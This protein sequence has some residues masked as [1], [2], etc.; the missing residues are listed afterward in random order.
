[1]RSLASMCSNASSEDAFDIAEFPS[2]GDIN[3][4]F[5][6]ADQQRKGASNFTTFPFPPSLAQ[7]PQLHA[8]ADEAATSD[9]RIFQQLA[10]LGQRGSVQGLGLFSSAG[11]DNFARAVSQQS[12]RSRSST[13][14][15]SSTLSSKSFDASTLASSAAN[16]SY[17]MRDKEADMEEA[18]PAEL[19]TTIPWFAQ[20][21]PTTTSRSLPPPIDPVL[22]NASSAHPALAS[23]FTSAASPTTRYAA[24]SSSLPHGKSPVTSRAPVRLESLPVESPAEKLDETGTAQWAPPTSWALM[25]AEEFLESPFEEKEVLMDELP[26][27]PMSAPIVRSNIPSSPS[28][29]SFPKTLKRFSSLGL[30]R[31]KKSEAV[32]RDSTAVKTNGA[33]AKDEA[34]PGLVKRK[35]EAALASLLRSRSGGGEKDKENV[36]AAPPNFRPVLQPV[37]LQTSKSPKRSA[38]SPRLAKLFSATPADP[39]APAVPAKDEGSSRLKKRLSSYFNQPRGGPPAPPLPVATSSTATKTRPPAVD[40][41]KANAGLGLARLVT[42]ESAQAS[43][44]PTL[45]ASTPS[46]VPPSSIFSE[47]LPPNTSS[48]LYSSFAASSASSLPAATHYALDNPLPQP[49][50]TTCFSAPPT[51]TQFPPLVPPS[52]AERPVSLMGFIDAPVRS[53]SVFP[54]T[55]LAQKRL[56]ARKTA[57]THSTG[58]ISPSGGD[59]RPTSLR[60]VDVLNAQPLSRQQFTA[61]VATEEVIAFPVHLPASH[62][63]AISP[64]TGS[65]VSDDEYGSESVSSDEDDDQPLGANPAALTA[66]KSLRLSAAKKS[67]RERKAREAKELEAKQ[68]ARQATALLKAAAKPEDPFELEKTAAMVGTSA[69]QDTRRLAPAQPAHVRPPISPAHSTPMVATVQSAGHASLLP[70]TDASIMRKATSFGM[71][72]SPS[73][74]LDPMVADSSLTIDSPELVQRPLPKRADSRLATEN[75]RSKSPTSTNESAMPA[76][77]TLAVTDPSMRSPTVASPSPVPPFRPPSV[78]STSA[79]SSSM[80]AFDRRPSAHRKVS[81]STASSAAGTPPLGRRPSL[82]PDSRAPAAAKRKVSESSTT[83]ASPALSRTSTLASRSRSATVSSAPPVEH[84]IYVDASFSKYLKVAVTDKTLAGEVV[85]LGKAKGALSKTTASEASEGGWALWEAWRST[86]LGEHVGSSVDS[87]SLTDEYRVRRRTTD[88]R[89]RARQRRPQVLGSGVERALLS[90]N[91][92]VAHLVRPCE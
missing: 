71:T 10:Q 82:H 37:Q 76:I 69:S 57:D 29:A 74:P 43:P 19:T 68:Q 7:D 42:I 92:N 58:A 64:C 1:M 91:N 53:T 46:S 66:Q 25:T 22:A 26:E 2:I 3:S 54:T 6:L 32:L 16:T 89:V 51:Q 87:S 73:S 86:G 70:Q 52:P 80:S 55:K 15:D 60:L 31:K 45:G 14:S 21:P 9:E 56:E 35:S 83:S 81:D 62:A 50:S 17:G 8:G 4:S 63:A 61:P 39:A 34:R 49:L 30:L 12:S 77:E 23:P 67:R 44:V 48:P 27:P 79:A 78:P 36:S 40:V 88:P 90:T 65:E 41:A 33:L 85:S 84:R 28:S 18:F 11:T 75:K 47:A 20:S 59:S 5:E 13:I 24:R 38:S 72:R